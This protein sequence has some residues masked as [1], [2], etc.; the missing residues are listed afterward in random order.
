V[1]GEV[2]QKRLPFFLCSQI[3]AAAVDPFAAFGTH[4]FKRMAEHGLAHGIAAKIF[5]IESRCG[6][7]AD[8]QH[9]V[10]IQQ[11]FKACFAFHIG[12]LFQQHFVEKPFDDSGHI[13]PPNRENKNQT[14]AF[15]N[16]LL[17]F[18]YQ[19]IK[20]LPLVEK[21]QLFFTVNGVETF[22]V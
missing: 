17:V 7:S 21:S 13:R 8:N 5:Q 14:A 3:H 2:V 22:R 1:F 18:L 20:R 10:N 16:H 6:G 9:F 11:P 15:F 12:K 4:T 19:R